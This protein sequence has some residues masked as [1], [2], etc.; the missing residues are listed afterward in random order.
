MLAH[1]QIAKVLPGSLRHLTEQ[2]TSQKFTKDVQASAG[3][4]RRS[5][6]FVLLLATEL[7]Y[8]SALQVRADEDQ[9]GPALKV[10]TQN[11]DARTDFGYLSRPAPRLLSCKG[12][13]GRL[14]RRSTRATFAATSRAAGPRNRAPP[15]SSGSGGNCKRSLYG[16]L[17]RSSLSPGS[18][19]SA[20]V[21]L[22]RST[23]V[24]AR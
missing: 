13:P 17:G 8:Q 6:I 15:Q 18:P 20:T 21:T 23:E 12:R 2:K 9:N 22:I 10:M 4:C 24:V 3:A 5:I 1:D 7:T 11:V 19:P 16:V 14:I